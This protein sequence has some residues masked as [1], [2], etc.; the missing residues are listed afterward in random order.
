MIQTGS[1]P[2]MKGGIWENIS[3]EAKHLVAS[4]IVLDPADRMSAE[5]AILHPWFNNQYN[6]VLI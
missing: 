5:S 6:T 4:L 2:P 1:Y 3:L